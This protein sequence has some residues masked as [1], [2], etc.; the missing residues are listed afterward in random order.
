MPHWTKCSQYIASLK[1]NTAT[2]CCANSQNSFLYLFIFIE[3]FILV[4]VMVHPES[5][6]GTLGMNQEYTLDA[7]PCPSYSTTHTHC[8]GHPWGPCKSPGLPSACFWEVG[9]NWRTYRIPT[10]TRGEHIRTGSYRSS[11]NSY[12]KVKDFKRHASSERFMF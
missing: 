6:Q 8:L 4:R 11:S 10:W 1:P 2:R 5:I 9:E 12:K 7:M 3:R